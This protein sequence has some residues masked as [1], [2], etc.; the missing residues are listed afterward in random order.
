MVIKTHCPTP[1]S[2]VTVGF[3]S[4]PLLI[5]PPTPCNHVYRPLDLPRQT[6]LE[7]KSELEGGGKS[8]P[9]RRGSLGVKMKW[10]VRPCPFPLPIQTPPVFVVMEDI[11]V[12][13]ELRVAGPHQ[14][15]RTVRSRHTS[16]IYPQ[17]PSEPYRLL[18]VWWLACT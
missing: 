12:L 2:M 3:G 1:S 11:A 13:P 5:L 15:Q 8:Q 18:R 14:G 9:V 7:T 10:L 6:F 16:S 4:F 17:T